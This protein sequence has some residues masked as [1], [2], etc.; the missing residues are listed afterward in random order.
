MKYIASVSWGK[1]SLAML[2][3]L[4]NESRPLDEVVFY[5]TGMEFN[6]I[7]EIRDKIVPIL[8][9]NSIKYTELSEE[10]KA[11]MNKVKEKGNELGELIDNI[12]DL[13]GG[14]DADAARCRA[15]AKTHIQTG[16]RRLNRSIARP[17]TFC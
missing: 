15:L 8:K 6:A 14:D 7:Y 3:R 17:R 2:I 11:L 13:I 5:D 1:D 16:K 4:I 10:Q 12:P 9:A